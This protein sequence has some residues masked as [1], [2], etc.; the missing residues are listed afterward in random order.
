M[1]KKY[2]YSGNRIAHAIFEFLLFAGVPAGNILQVAGYPADLGDIMRSALGTD[3]FSAERAVLDTRDDL[4]GAV[5]VVKRAHDLKVR[6]AAFRTRLF[7][8]DEVTGVALVFALLFRNIVQFSCIFEPMFVVLQSNPY[9]I[10][11]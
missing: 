1:K 4:V 11:A 5:A 6:L 9:Y 2:I 8:D 7:V 10:I 3:S